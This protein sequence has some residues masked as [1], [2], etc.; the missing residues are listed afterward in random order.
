[1]KKNRNSNFCTKSRHLKKINK[2]NSESSSNRNPKV[3]VELFRKL[4]CGCFFLFATLKC[5]T[6]GAFKRKCFH[7][8][9]HSIMRFWWIF[10]FFFA[11]C[12]LCQQISIIRFAMLVHSVKIE[13]FSPKKVVFCVLEKHKSVETTIY[14]L[15]AWFST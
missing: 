3:K 2:L 7:Q 9:Y 10:L 14:H 1:M 5:W 4:N 8:I 13:Y 15:K 11:V 12:R 6:V